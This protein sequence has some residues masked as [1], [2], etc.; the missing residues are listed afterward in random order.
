MMA[1]L[2][3]LLSMTTEKKLSTTIYEFFRVWHSWNILNK[4]LYERNL[5][6]SDNLVYNEFDMHVYMYL[7][8]R[9]FGLN[10]WGEEQCTG[11]NEHIRSR[12]L[13]CFQSTHADDWGGYFLEQQISQTLSVTQIFISESFLFGNDLIPW[14]YTNFLCSYENRSALQLEIITHKYCLSLFGYGFYFIVRPSSA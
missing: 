3:E 5:L 6:F 13:A 7:N 2:G 14:L 8:V 11:S 9:L 12:F 4:V 10:N 1:N